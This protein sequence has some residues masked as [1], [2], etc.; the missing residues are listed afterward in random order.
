MKS[1]NIF[2]K[3]AFKNKEIFTSQFLLKYN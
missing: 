3:E 1:N 2:V